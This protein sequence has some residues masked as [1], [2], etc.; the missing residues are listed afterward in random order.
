MSLSNNQQV[1]ERETIFI[2]KRSSVFCLPFVTLFLSYSSH[3][4]PLTNFLFSSF[5]RMS[6]LLRIR[7]A[8]NAHKYS[9]CLFRKKIPKRCTT[10]LKCFRFHVKSTRRSNKT[11]KERINHSEANDKKVWLQKRMNSSNYRMSNRR[12]KK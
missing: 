7:D 5:A 3:F 8:I 2:L 10:E 1:N 12:N 4:L 11:K 6:P 9:C